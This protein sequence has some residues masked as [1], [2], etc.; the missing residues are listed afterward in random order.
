MITYGTIVTYEGKTGT[1]T[2]IET[3]DGV[4]FVNVLFENIEEVTGVPLS[5]C[6]IIGN[7]ATG[8]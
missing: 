2:A 3:R 5:S 1:I 6:T 8:E 7:N 4:E